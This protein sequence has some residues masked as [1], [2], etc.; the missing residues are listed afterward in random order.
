VAAIERF[1]EV[2]SYGERTGRQLLKHTKEP[3][4]D[5]AEG[6]IWRKDDQFSIADELLAS[7]SFK[8]VVSAVLEHGFVIVPRSA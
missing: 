5:V 3:L 1:V 4:P 8:S 2:G 7:P 6:C